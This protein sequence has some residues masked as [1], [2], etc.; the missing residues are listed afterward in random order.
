MLINKGSNARGQ[1]WVREENNSEKV[2]G[3]KPEGLPHKSYRD[4]IC[5]PPFRELI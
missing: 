2:N 4:L 3:G 5:V 1:T